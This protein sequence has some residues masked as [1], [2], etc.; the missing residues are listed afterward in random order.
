MTNFVAG[1]ASQHWSTVQNALWLATFGQSGGDFPTTDGGTETFADWPF[2]HA[3]D[4]SVSLQGGSRLIV[5]N[6]KAYPLEAELKICSQDTRVPWSFGNGEGFVGA[7]SRGATGNPSEAGGS[8]G[9]EGG[10]GGDVA[11][12]LDGTIIVAGN[13]DTT[14]TTTGDAP[15]IGVLAASRG[16]LGVLYEQGLAA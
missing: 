15:L 11:L 7:Y 10:D 16:G 5:T 14:F 2:I 9:V 3:G 12:T 13:G 6:A 8:Y 4:L 1:T